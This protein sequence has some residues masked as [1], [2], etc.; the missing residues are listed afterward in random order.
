MFFGLYVWEFTAAINFPCSKT[1]LR[2]WENDI[3]PHWLK[4]L[5]ITIST[6]VRIKNNK[7]FGS[8]I[9]AIVYINCYYHINLCSSFEKMTS[10]SQILKKELDQRTLMAAVNFRK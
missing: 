5:I 4:L 10:F 8:Y 9:H 1:S 7:N 6:A 2:I 3:T